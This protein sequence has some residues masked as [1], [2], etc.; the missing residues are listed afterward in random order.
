MDEGKT[1]A[2]AERSGAGD[3][4]TT[5]RMAKALSHPLR[6]SILIR[7]NE[8]PSSPVQLSRQ[9]DA[10]VARVAY[11][12]K[13][14]EELDCIELVELRPVRGSVEHIYRATR[15]VLFEEED[16]EKLPESARR[17][18]TAEWFRNA[19]R[20]IAKSMETGE[21][22]RRND[23]HF[24]T[25]PLELDAAGWEHLATR[26]MDLVKEALDITAE[27]QAAQD[28]REL[29]KAGLVMTLFPRAD[30]TPDGDADEAADAAGEGA[31]IG[32]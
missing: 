8:R 32:A 12:V 2:V 16:W 29:V 18:M 4:D 14:L 5:T 9:L 15:R 6:A 24:S 23:T 3:L 27:A 13:L 7:L 10:P 20:S 11:H 1:Q 26:L 21:F 22:E 19:F 28:G 31:A 30:E 25:T 17:G